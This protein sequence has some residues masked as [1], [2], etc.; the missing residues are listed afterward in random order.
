MSLIWKYF[1]LKHKNKYIFCIFVSI[2]ACEMHCKCS[3][4][5]LLHQL[6]SAKEKPLK[7]YREPFC[8]VIVCDT[9]D[10]E[11]FEGDRYFQQILLTASP[12]LTTLKAKLCNTFAALRV[13]L[14]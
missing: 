14:E 1:G 11:M 3:E 10:N 4:S 5:L 12:A 13:E 6:L 8:F 7:D 9:S 2:N